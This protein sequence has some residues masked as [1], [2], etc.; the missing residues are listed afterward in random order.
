MRRFLLAALPALLVLS[1]GVLLAVLGIGA[2]DNP[3]R[4]A[5]RCE[6]CHLNDPVPGDP[7]LF[8]LDIDSLCS[9]CHLMPEKNSHP[10]RIL[11]SQ[12]VP[13]GFPLDWQGRVTCATCHDPHAEDFQSNPDLLRSEA[14]GRYFCLLCHERLL[15][16][17]NSHLGVG[18]MA[19]AK[20]STQP[21]RETLER[22]LDR[23][24]LECLECHD[25]L[26]GPDP[27]YRVLGDESLT[28]RE[29]MLSHPIGVDY[30][31]AARRSRHLKPMETL[32]PLISL[33]EG[34]VGCG[35]CHNPYSREL[36]MLVFSDRRSA[37][38]LSCHDK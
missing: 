37:L 25:G 26:I 13:E 18:G 34:K 31:E 6:M 33:Y 21:D 7:G 22:V 14:R 10:S 35:S 2:G 4:F 24:S 38:C 20:S 3:H 30:R 11:P 17:S 36:G 19:H 15:A 32:P 12:P 8:V 28:Y 16:D 27:G 5:G 23:F 29:R 9:G 1:A